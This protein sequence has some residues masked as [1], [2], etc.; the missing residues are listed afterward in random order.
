MRNI[1]QKCQK[2]Q[3][4]MT[5]R[6]LFTALEFSF[7]SP[8]QLP[9]LIK[10]SPGIGK[11]DIVE[12]VCKKI[13]YELIISHPVVGD[14]TDYKGLPFVVDGNAVFLPFGDLKKL[15]EAKHPLVFFLD[16]LGQASP[17]VQSA[18]MQLILAQQINGHK[19]SKHVRFVAATNRREDRANVSGILEPVKS[20]FA[21]I[22]QLEID[23]EDWLDW[24]R[25]NGMPLEL[26]F[27][28]QSNPKMLNAFK[29]TRDIENTPCP[30]TVAYVGKMMNAGLPNSIWFEMV[31]GAAGASFASGLKFFI[32]TFMQLPTIAQ[33]ESNPYGT[34]MPQ[35]IESRFALAS[36]M[37]DKMTP[38][39]IDKLIIYT[40]KMEKELQVSI[41]KTAIERNPQIGMNQAFIHWASKNQVTLMNAF[42]S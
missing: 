16:D 8:T 3:N 26:L 18:V 40:E 34:P 11:S 2:L 38:A 41:I 20:R 13:G 17:A 19:I 35:H 21:S 28:I 6:E 31:S 1:P 9:V 23:V 30:R 7:L 24:G 10:G 37:I 25:K 22:V 29:A 4:I 39:N 5:P 15:L 14:P 33:I 27:F 12:Q 36:I 32:D 42:A